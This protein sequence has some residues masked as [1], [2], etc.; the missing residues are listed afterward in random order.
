MRISLSSMADPFVTSIAE[1][2]WFY[3]RSVNVSF[4]FVFFFLFCYS[5][6][7]TIDER[8]VVVFCKVLNANFIQERSRN[9]VLTT[10]AIVVGNTFVK[11]VLLVLLSLLLLLLSLNFYNILTKKFN[12]LGISLLHKLFAL[13]VRCGMKV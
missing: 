12:F 5:H 3:L 4:C 8:I 9:M 7:K 2:K 6:C 1:E 11:L 13:L 10:I